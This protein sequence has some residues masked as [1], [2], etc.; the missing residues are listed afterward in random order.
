MKIKGT[1]ESITKDWPKPNHVKITQSGFNF[2]H[3]RMCFCFHYTDKD[4]RINKLVFNNKSVD[5]VS[6]KET[7]AL[8]KL[9]PAIKVEELKTAPIS[10]EN[11]VIKCIDHINK[12]IALIEADAARNNNRVLVI[13]RQLTEELK[14]FI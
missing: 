7:E 8:F 1:P 11:G 13:L 6:G 12:K 4:T 9:V 10:S 5:F 2:Y 14:Q 3:K